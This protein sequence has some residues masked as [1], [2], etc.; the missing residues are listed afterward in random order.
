MTTETLTK[1]KEF[2]EQNPANLESLKQLRLQIESAVS[3]EHLLSEYLAL[4]K[5]LQA[6]D[7]ADHKLLYLTVW[8][9]LNTLI[10]N[11]TANKA[12]SLLA[13]HYA[14]QLKKY[15]AVDPDLTPTSLT[16]LQGTLL[17]SWFKK[18]PDDIEAREEAKRYFEAA[19]ALG[20]ADSEW[21]L[22][23]LKE[24]TPDALK[25]ISIMLLVN[26]D[27]LVISGKIDAQAA[28]ILKQLYIDQVIDKEGSV[29]EFGQMT[30][31]N[32]PEIIAELDKL[33]DKFIVEYIRNESLI[34]GCKGPFIM[35]EEHDGER[36][37]EYISD[38]NVIEY[39]F[40]DLS[41]YIE[42]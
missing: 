20:D 21:Y 23:K 40:T 31:T 32:H 17:Y 3:P 12:D 37:F 27:Q 15:G 35:E 16:R 1:L 14:E 4:A 19:I 10:S 7:T 38:R 22:N 5:E 8:Q 34:E 9:G 30:K 26:G 42:D 29:E 11:P 18:H 36:F 2:A 33:R 39:D 41:E 6:D 25:Q 24:A 28:K 13:V